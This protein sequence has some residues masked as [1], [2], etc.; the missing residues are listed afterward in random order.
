MDDRQ[1]TIR[2]NHRPKKTIEKSVYHEENTS[3][4]IDNPDFL[5][6][7]QYK[8]QHHKKRCGVTDII[9]DFGSHILFFLILKFSGNFHFVR[10]Q[11]G[12]IVGFV[13]SEFSNFSGKMLLNSF[14][15]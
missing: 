7:F 13:N 1:N 5:K 10:H 12:D 14:R 15:P 4:Q 3:D 8:T 11:I 2:N 9:G 6:I